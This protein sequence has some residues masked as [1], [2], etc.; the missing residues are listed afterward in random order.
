MMEHGLEKRKLYNDR[1]FSFKKSDLT[2]AEHY[3]SSIDKFVN[4]NPLP[5][6]PDERTISQY[7][8][9]L[10]RESE[11]IIETKQK[12]PFRSV[13]DMPRILAL[14][15]VLGAYKDIVAESSKE[16]FD[17]ARKYFSDK[18]VVETA[19]LHNG[20]RSED[21]DIQYVSRINNL[22]ARIDYDFKEIE[23]ETLSNIKLMD[24]RGPSFHFN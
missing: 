11:N 20:E 4:D 8:L 9:E 21:M 5:D 6:D 22:Y 1:E 14:Y 17:K 7:H 10:H 13:D 2:A 16:T 23:E 12:K 24:G 19:L 18:I 15:G 3:M